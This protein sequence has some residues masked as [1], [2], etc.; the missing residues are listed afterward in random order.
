MYG[1][2]RCTVRDQYKRHV[3]ELVDTSPNPPGSASPDATAGKHQWQE[4]GNQADWSFNGSAEGIQTLEQR[5]RGT[6][7][8]HIELAV[9]PLL[10]GLHFATHHVVHQLSSAPHAWCAQASSAVCA[11]TLRKLHSVSASPFVL[12]PSPHPGGRGEGGGGAAGGGSGGTESGAK[13][14]AR[15]NRRVLRRRPK[16]GET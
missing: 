9:L 6:I 8:P 11:R 12:R 15:N 3:G 2:N 13:R 5:A 4:K 14:L 10:L 1:R 16:H 7:H